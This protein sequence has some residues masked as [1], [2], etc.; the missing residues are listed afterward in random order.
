MP[1]EL[2]EKISKEPLP[3]TITEIE[4][5]DKLRVLRASG[6]VAAFLPPLAIEKPF[7]RV[8]AITELGWEALRD[9][10]SAIERIDQFPPVNEKKL[11]VT[12]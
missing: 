1:L 8:L 10:H 6:H 7:A 5:I 9:F 12:L 2:L 4:E 3:L 11:A